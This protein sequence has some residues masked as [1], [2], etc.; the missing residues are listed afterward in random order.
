MER[1]PT[2]T[3]GLEG[4]KVKTCLSQILLQVRFST[5]ISAAA[6][7]LEGGRRRLSAM[8]AATS[9][10][11][12]DHGIALPRPAEAPSTGAAAVS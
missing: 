4:S 8:A 2:C 5:Q 11:R 6:R 10:G 7:G 1:V 3:L 12:H 9:P